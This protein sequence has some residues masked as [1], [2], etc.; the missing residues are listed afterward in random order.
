MQ[1]GPYEVRSRLGEGGMGE[2]FRAR[3]PR[4]HREVAIKL[5]QTGTA[6]WPP[7]GQWIAYSRQKGTRSEVA[8]TQPGSAAGVQV[9]SAAQPSFDRQYATIQWS[10]A[11]DWILYPAADGLA[12]VS[13]DNQA[14]RKLTSRKF[15]AYGFSKNGRA[16]LGIL[17]SN[18]PGTPEWQ[19]LSVDVATSAETKLGTIDFPPTTSAVAGFS[20]HPGGNRFATSI[21]KLPYDIWILEGFDER[22]SWFDRVLGR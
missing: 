10:P 5:L 1:I 2:I 9:L 21:S 18:S 6:A 12:L 11:G 7:D 4:L 20:M 16:V 13:Q 17:R 8:K 3:D 15:A 19:L 14:N 22:K